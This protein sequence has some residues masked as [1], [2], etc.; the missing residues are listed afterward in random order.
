MAVLRVLAW[1]GMPTAAALEQAGQR[2]GVGVEVT[3]ISSNEQL[4]ERLRAAPFDLIFPSDYLVERLVARGALL[5]LDCAPQTLAQIVHWAREAPHDPG[6]EYSLP[7]AFGTTGYLCDE[8]FADGGTW[9]D[10]LRPAAGVAVGMLSEPREV[11]GAALMATGHSPN[12]VSP[13]ALTNARRLL[14]RQRPSVARFDSDDF[15]GPVV[16]GDVAAHQAWSGPASVAV[17]AHSR[18][19]YVVPAEG[20]GLWITTAAVP[21]TAPDA[22]GAHKLL[23]ALA[24]PELAAL[25]TLNDGYATPNVAA[26]ALLPGDLRADTVLFPSDDVV[27]RCRT[28]HDLGE[29]ESLVAAIYDELV[30]AG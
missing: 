3:V 24:A 10:L 30:A 13:E 7:F 29:R 17:R 23:A 21:A 16:R 2:L 4:E 12:D 20:A 5:P 27:R 1:P 11:V 28:F 22:S 26:R 6:C 9:H 18:L 19:R 14:W 25:T 8:A 15:V